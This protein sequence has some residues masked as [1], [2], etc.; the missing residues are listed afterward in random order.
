MSYF[1]IWMHKAVNYTYRKVHNNPFPSLIITAFLLLTALGISGSS[2]G[3]F[4][5]IFIGHAPGI[6]AGSP[7][8]IRSDEWLVESQ[9]TLIQRAANY[10]SV[11]DNVGLG[12]DMTMIL[13]VPSRSIFSVFKPHDFFFFIMPYV[14]AFAAKWWFMSMVLV[15]GFYYL[16]D[17]LFP[18]K[19]LIISLASLILLFNPF[20]QWWYRPDILLTIGYALWACFMI[21]KLFEQR[22]DNRSLVLYTSGLAYSTLCFIFLLYPPFQLAVAY[23]I[24]ALLAG[25]F[26]YRYANQR[27][28]FKQDLKPWIAVMAA[29]IAV[30]LV[31]GIFFI[32]HKNIINTVTYT[33]YPG[34][35][36]IISGQSYGNQNGGGLNMLYTFSAPILFNNQNEAKFS[37]FYTNQSEAARIVVINL[38]ILPVFLLGVLN[39]PRK[40]RALADYLLISTSIMAVVFMVRMFTPFF[41]LPFKLLLFDKVQNERLAFGLVLLCAIQLVL[42]GAINIR[43]IS[44]KTAGIMALLVFGLS[45]DASMMLV[46]QYP[47]FISSG[48]VLIACLIIGLAAF[49]MLQKKYFTWGLALF[50]IFSLA[51]SVFVNPLYHRSEPVALQSAAN[52][53]SSRYHDGKSW[54]VMDSV[55]IENIPAVAGEHSLSGVQIYPQLD[56][57]K[58]L[59]APAAETPAYNRYAHVVFSATTPNNLTFY[60]P[61]P[62]VLMVHFDCDIAKKLPNFG[63][64]LSSAPITDPTFTQ[65]M[66]LDSTIPYPKV[67]LNIYKYSPN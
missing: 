37:L 52:Q 39:K 22:S 11:N 21:V 9:E 24:V 16:M 38:L 30:V 42:F 58:S 25:Y 46:H 63:Y 34:I 66:K 32:T 51:S 27:V 49:L 53:V 56:L 8:P 60:N 62:D 67:T 4:D 26:Y 54:V 19:R 10:P 40:E 47:K 35:R 18:N 65:C 2:M 13:D 5:Q 3:A 55:I 64:A 33:A 28:K 20:V 48:A 45:F 50:T 31:A 41:N 57:W 23:M 1:R 43:K 29:A 6:L 14:N 61:Q 44:V 7:K 17:I 15:L 12:Q 59:G 36:S